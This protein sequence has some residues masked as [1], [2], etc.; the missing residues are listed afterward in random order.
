M[1]SVNR[2]DLFAGAVGLAFVLAVPAPALAQTDVAATFIRDVARLHPMAAAMAR[3]AIA[4]GL[5]PKALCEIAF[6]RGP[7]GQGLM[8]CF[9]TGDTFVSWE[10]DR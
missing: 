2:R 10:E 7:D 6:D 8:F 9:T 5:D 3:R 1:T 4:A